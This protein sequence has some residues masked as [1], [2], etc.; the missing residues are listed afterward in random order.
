M[1]NKKIRRCIITLQSNRR[2]FALMFTRQPMLRFLS[3]LSFQ[4]EIRISLAKIRE[5]KTESL[6]SWFQLLR[7]KIIFYRRVH[8]LTSLKQFHL[9]DGE[10]T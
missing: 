7:C 5:I 1:T 3:F 10:A 9:I 6:G 2:R 8:P 4:T